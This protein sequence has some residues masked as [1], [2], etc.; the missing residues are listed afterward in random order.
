MKV[1]IRFHLKDIVR[2][3]LGLLF[4][5]AAVSKLADPMKFY[6]S[7]L[8]YQM[9]LP[10]L[11]LRMSAVALPWMELLCGLALLANVWTVPALLVTLVLFVAFIGST[12]QAWMRDLDISCGCFNLEIFGLKA[13]SP[14]VRLIES[15]SFAFFRNLVL[16]VAAVWLFRTSLR[17][18]PAEPPPMIRAISASDDDVDDM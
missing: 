1:Q 8:Q 7:L 10:D 15:A 11:L 5:W 14:T 13:D 12:G 4:V 18:T 16:L 17:T 2:L 6:T 9:P 3:L